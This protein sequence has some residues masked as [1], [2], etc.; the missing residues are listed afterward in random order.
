[1]PHS[2][3][4]CKPIPH[5]PHHCVCAL[6]ARSKHAGRPRLQVHCRLVKQNSL[7]SKMEGMCVALPLPAGS[8]GSTDMEAA[9]ARAVDGFLGNKPSP[10][11]PAGPASKGAA[12]G[13]ASGSMQEA[14]GE[15][16]AS[17]QQGAVGGTGMQRV[18]K[19]RWHSASPLFVIVAAERCIAILHQK[20]T[21]CSLW[22][23]QFI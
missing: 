8:A 6:N 21:S 10:A 11:G 23:A 13:P 1:M 4:I 18:G 2:R 15:L 17:I 7:L 19:T 3:S 5:C 14:A 16:G 20:L 12:P 9:V 22:P